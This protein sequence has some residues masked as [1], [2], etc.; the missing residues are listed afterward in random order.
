[1]LHDDPPARLL[2]RYS[3]PTSHRVIELAAIVAFTGSASVFAW[4]VVAELGRQASPGVVA[5]VVG[6]VL[7]G[8]VT[9]DLAS[10]LVHA[11]C[12]NLGSVDTPVVGQ[13]FIRSFREHHVDPLDM[14]RGDFVRVNADN[15]LAS[16]PLVVPAVLWLDVGR[17]LY[18]G[19]F[20]LALLAFAIV[21]NQIHKWAHMG[22]VPSPVRR[23]QR[24]GIVLSPE[25]HAVH[26]TAPH[27][28]NYCITSGISN[29]VLTRIRFW[30][31]LLWLCRLPTRGRAPAAVGSPSPVSAAPVADPSVAGPLHR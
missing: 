13:K 18:L 30:P 25:H 11:L 10:G 16:L 17:H 12:D 15:F 2:G 22:S 21:T 31:A 26:H 29:P 4:R 19:S 28:S 24:S 9:A 27:D 20:L 5:G 8:Y 3:Y 1:V 6:A 23:L 14:T 7:A